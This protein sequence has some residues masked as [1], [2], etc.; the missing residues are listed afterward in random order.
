MTDEYHPYIDRDDAEAEYK[1]LREEIL[2]SQKQRVTLLTATLAFI[3]GLFSFMA[4]DGDFEIY[5]SS[6]LIILTIPASLYSY[7]TRV[8]ERRIANYITVFMPRFSP[9]SRASSSI[10]EL[11]LN[12]LQRA[13]TSMIVG[14][15]LL[16]II[17]F[18]LPFHLNHGLESCTLLVVNCVAILSNLT[19]FLVTTN[20]KDF[21][22]GFKTL[23]SEYE[24]TGMQ[25]P[26][27]SFKSER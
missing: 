8:R 20:L 13:S 3:G 27:K 18:Y 12:P 24:K 5:Q 1:S 6:L 25:K 26:N 10:D 16:N 14:I 17:L 15:L 19:I 9:W 23:L 2:Q 4:K 7:A 22:G 11:K 21:S